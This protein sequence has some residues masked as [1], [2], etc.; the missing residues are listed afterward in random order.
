MVFLKSASWVVGLLPVLVAC[1][2][3]ARVAKSDQWSAGGSPQTEGARDALAAADVA[4]EVAVSDLVL[5]LVSLALDGDMI[6]VPEDIAAPV[7]TA[8]VPSTTA[9]PTAIA[10]ATATPPETQG[11][12]TTPAVAP[13]AVP[14]VE[15]LIDIKYRK[16]L[17]AV[18]DYVHSHIMQERKE[19]LARMAK[20]LKEVHQASGDKTEAGIK[21]RMKKLNEAYELFGTKK[22]EIMKKIEESREELR[23]L[24]DSLKEVRKSCLVPESPRTVDC[25]PLKLE[26]DGSQFRL[27][28]KR[29]QRERCNIS[30]RTYWSNEFSKHVNKKKD[31]VSPECRAAW[32]ALAKQVNYTMPAEDLN[33]PIEVPDVKKQ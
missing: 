27:V 1:A 22:E 25:H 3:S 33:E 28:W 13:I 14:A 7:E 15:P 26:R 16:V 21:E 5:D 12:A 30:L 29:D 19:V 4:P 18:K 31:E 24:R 32:L 17:L 6:E 9:T 23:A 10:T 11:D 20:L 8:E 2:P